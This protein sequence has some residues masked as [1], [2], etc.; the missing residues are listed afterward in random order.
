VA[1]SPDARTL[2]H[3]GRRK[4]PWPTLIWALPLAA[5]IIVAY[6]A[7]QWV[8]ERGE[9]V[10]VTFA[11]AGGARVGETKVTYQGVEAGHLIK[12]LPN[13]DG[14][15]IDF[16]LRLVPEAKPG[17]NTNARFFLIGASPAFDLNSLRAVVSG[18]SIGYAPG[19]GGTPT[20]TFE[21]LDTAP[22]VL[23]GDRGTR[24]LLTARTLGAIHEGAV[25]LFHGQLVG[26]V[27]DVKLTGEAFR[28]EVFVFQPYDSL[29]KTGARFWRVSPLR[30]SFAGGGV[31]ANLAPLSAIVSGGV[32]LDTAMATPESPQSRPES[33][34]T[35]YSSKTAAEQGLS[36]PTV[37]YAF[38]FASDAG[39]LEEG[40]AVTLLGFQVGEIES[41]RLTYDEHTG[42]PLTTVTASLY[43]QQLDP[44]G[45]APGSATDWRTVTDE[46][47]RQLIRFGYRAR[48]EQSPPLVGTRSIALVQVTGAPAANL[49]TD[50]VNLRFPSAA[51]STSLDDIASQA[52]QILA[53][54][55]RIPIEE[56]GQ[57]LK[58]VTRRLA[59]LISSPQ[60]EDSLSHLSRSLAQLD[61]ML[62]QVQPQI[63]PLV[64]KL[65]DAAGQVSS[66]SLAVRRLLDG[67]GAAQDSSLPEAIRELNEAARSIRTLADYLDRHPEALIRGK[68]PEK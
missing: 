28:L 15:R 38:S 65:N 53:K 8:A 3:A 43:P 5:L 58:V 68:R 47:V 33:E 32:E 56:I 40:A 57:N 18:V 51:G 12:I 26:K 52:D 9:I 6:L 48:L 55:N 13:K 24:Y 1:D 59:S 31:N 66:I 2:P 49:T 17:L 50:G 39:D 20:R 45:L 63:G 46:K 23:P 30:L 22:T 7:V 14:H 4:T 41:A 29:I 11:R 42:K 25:L 67:E 44:K 21:G 34:F 61:L 35:L 19:D 64:S 62:G 54:V 10:T 16:K 27:S 60:I 37:R 36:G